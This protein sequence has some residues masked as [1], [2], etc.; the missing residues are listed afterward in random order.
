M[1]GLSLQFINPPTVCGREWA[2]AVVTSSLIGRY[3]NKLVY[4]LNHNA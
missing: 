3:V 2:N 4:L 1:Y